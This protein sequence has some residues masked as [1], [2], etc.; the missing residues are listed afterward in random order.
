MVE[1]LPRLSTT[2]NISGDYTRE[3][4]YQTRRLAPIHLWLTPRSRRRIH[5]RFPTRPSPHAGSR[6]NPVDAWK[7]S[8]QLSRSVRR[9]P[10]HRLEL[11][12]FCG[13]LILLRR[14]FILLT[15]FRLAKS[16]KIAMSHIMHKW[17]VWVKI[18]VA[19]MYTA[20]FWLG[21]IRL[22]LWWGMKHPHCPARPAVSI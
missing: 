5:A 16:R 20:I 21:F 4:L 2:P 12:R 3:A 14:S 9:P 6:S 15:P 11:T 8:H 7:G 13:Y 19:P 18:D 10:R 1:G 17:S 22:V